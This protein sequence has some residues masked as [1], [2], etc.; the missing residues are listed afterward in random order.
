MTNK[1]NAANNRESTNKHTCT[2]TDTI[3]N[4]MKGVFILMVIK[5]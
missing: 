3:D 4:D 1:M 5:R 2:L